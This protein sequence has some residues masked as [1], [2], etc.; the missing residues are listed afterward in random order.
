[1]NFFDHNT[2]IIVT[3]TGRSTVG[4]MDI[5]DTVGTITKVIV[6]DDAYSF[7][8]HDAK[9]DVE[10]YNGMVSVLHFEIVATL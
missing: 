8:L 6:H 7:L 9:G 4:T 1:M 5:V 3:A 10:W 2:T